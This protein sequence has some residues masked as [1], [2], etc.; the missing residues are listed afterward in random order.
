MRRVTIKDVAREAGV[1]F[2]AVSRTFTEGASVSSKTRAK[3]QAA[4]EKLH[5]RPS[6]VGRALARSRANAVTLV[7]GRLSDPFDTIFLEKLAEVL[8]VR[9]RRLILSLARQKDAG[10]DSLLQALDDQSEA[11]VVSAGTM[12]LETVERCTQAGLPVILAGRVLHRPGID[13][14]VPD[15]IEGGRLAAQ[16]TRR[17]G[18]QRPGFF[19]QAHTTFS[20]RERCMG[21]TDGLA[22]L[23]CPVHRPAEDSDDAIFDAAVTMLSAPDRPD[24]LFC[25]TDR[26]ALHALEAA[27]ALSLKVPQD[28]SLIGFNNIPAAARRSFRLT[29]IDYAIETL[30]EQIMDL[31]DRRLASPDAEAEVRRIPVRLVVRDTTVEAAT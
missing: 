11:V 27:K 5:Y 22:P 7:V 24:S 3:V 14:V 15:N 23:P 13:C 31:L 2:S 16:L 19:G 26:L 28:V 6:N 25:A 17:S 4:A 18:R 12:S 8:S 20:D 30:V 9:G 10:G 29:T 1:S 21:F